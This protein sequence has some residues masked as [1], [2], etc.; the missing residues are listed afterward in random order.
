MENFLMITH[1]RDKSVSELRLD[2]RKQR[3]ELMKA[4]F[5]KASNQLKDLSKIRVIRRSIAKIL[6]ALKEKG[7]KK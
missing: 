2:D 4:R 1:L 3:E 5:G 7:E 6:T